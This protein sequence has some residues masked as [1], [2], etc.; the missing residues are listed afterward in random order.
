MDKFIEWL[1]LHTPLTERTIKEYASAFK[2]IADNLAQS[3][4]IELFSIDSK[5]LKE[6]QKIKENYFSIEENRDTDKRSN[7][8][9]PPGAAMEVG[10]TAIP[11][12]CSWR[13][14]DSDADC[15]E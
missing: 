15:V 4:S 14:W 2:R 6:L 7:R 12:A 1:K 9:H 11:W 10:W 5:D 3:N 13:D 8:R